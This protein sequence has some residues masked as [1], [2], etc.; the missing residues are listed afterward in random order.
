LEVCGVD[1]PNS[2]E[3]AIFD[4][5]GVQVNSR[6][7]LEFETMLTRL[8]QP[9]AEGDITAGKLLPTIVNVVLLP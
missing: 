3:T 1:A 9:V 7:V 2:T 4:P 6:D 8:E 5:S